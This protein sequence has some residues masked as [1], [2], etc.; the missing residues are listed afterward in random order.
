MIQVTQKQDAM[1]Q[2]KCDTQSISNQVERYQK[3]RI[4]QCR[5]PTKLKSTQT[6]LVNS[7][8]EATQATPD[9]IIYVDF[10]VQHESSLA[11]QC[12]GIKPGQREPISVSAPR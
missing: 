7:S 4:L 10:A 2:T 8:D 11:D 12:V 5:T 1:C 6:T 3:N 9:S